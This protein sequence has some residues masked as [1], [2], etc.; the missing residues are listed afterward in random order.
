MPSSAIH[1]GD[2]TSSLKAVLLTGPIIRFMAA[3]QLLNEA[4]ASNILIAVLQGLQ[5]HGQHES[6]QVSLLV[7]RLKLSDQF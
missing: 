2:S 4:I 1:W 6:N 3:E 7:F 5:Q